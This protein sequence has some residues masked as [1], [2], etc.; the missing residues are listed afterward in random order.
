MYTLAP[1]ASPGSQ[2]E[3]ESKEKPRVQV[4]QENDGRSSGAVSS[5]AVLVDSSHEHKKK[6]DGREDALHI[7]SNVPSEE[8]IEMSSPGNSYAKED[9]FTEMISTAPQY[10]TQDSL[11][12]R[13]TDEKTALHQSKT[14]KRKSNVEDELAFPDLES[15]SCDDCYIDDAKTMIQG[16]LSG[17]HDRRSCYGLFH[18]SVGRIE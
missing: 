15:A 1:A 17:N 3:E 18:R 4:V 7:E 10:E 9:N 16:V 11:V 12:G 14:L 5:G 6:N 13:L 8:E 2:R